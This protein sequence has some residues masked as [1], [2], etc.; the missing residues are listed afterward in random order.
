MVCA[1][2]HANQ[3]RERGTREGAVR[4]RSPS[5]LKG[6]SHD[7][8]DGVIPRNRLAAVEGFA[9]SDT[10]WG[11]KRASPGDDATELAFPHHMRDRLTP[12][13]AGAPHLGEHSSK[14][15]RAG[16]AVR[17]A[18][19]ELPPVVAEGHHGAAQ[20]V[21]ELGQ[22]KELKV[23]VA[24]KLRR[25]GGVQRAHPLQVV[26]LQ[27]ELALGALGVVTVGVLIPVE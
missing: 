10:R 4:N 23:P 17:A 6:A 27:H 7:G 14:G 15:E 2:Q 26:N 13:A 5:V 11:E 25:R 16:G 3:A 24:R 12:L 8:G 1:A 21:V 19:Q 9:E 22:P 18:A 20:L